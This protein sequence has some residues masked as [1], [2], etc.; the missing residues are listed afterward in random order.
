MKLYYSFFFLSLFVI[1][2]SIAQEK[3]NIIVIVSDD[4]G[5][6][7]FSFQSDKLTATPNIDRIAHEGAKF[8]NAYVT[9]SV[10]SPSR[11]GLLSG[12]NQPEF[13]HIYNY[14]KG[15][16]YSIDQDEYG[17][18]HNVKMIGEYL[19]PLGYATAA[20]GK[21]HEGFAEEFQ[22]QQKGF[23]HFWGFL[24]GSNHYHTG[25]AIDV[26]DNG[27]PV[28]A[29]TIP[30][31]TDAI[32]DEALKFASKNSE[33]PFFLYMAYN[34]VHSPLEAKPEH[35]E[36]FK[37]TF[38]GDP[39]RDILAAMTYSLD[40]NIGKVFDQLDTMGELENT[41]IFF[42]NDNGGSKHISANNSPLKGY[43]GQLYEGGIR[44]P[45]AV[46][47][48]GKINR[49]T[50]CHS[51]TSSLD[52]LPSILDA[53]GYSKRNLEGKSVLELINKPQEQD[54]R[55]LY[56]HTS[57]YNGAV[58]SGQWKLI[59]NKGNHELYNLDQD[60]AEEDDLLESN[61]Q[62]YQKMKE[63][64]DQWLAQLP[65]PYFVPTSGKN[66]WVSGEGD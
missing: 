16:T 31:M 20:F 55:E 25:K 54:H 48:P 36:M 42:I 63:K 52:I 35:V 59:V 28:D 2:G 50:V 7:D 49:E 15:V 37:G 9:A 66:A 3:P 44:V 62:Q 60:L 4:A 29:A 53:V 39:K 32:T 21:W 45:F 22:P 12:I 38:P 43:K 47:W 26:I 57:Q 10:C 56:W 6:A 58:R 13:G 40:E 33:K 41:I 17:L 27:R 8:T 19:Q 14:I 64:Y 11:A 61:P 51:I 18:P 23:D 1:T 34:A 5:Y 24:W 65:H 30:Y 46:R